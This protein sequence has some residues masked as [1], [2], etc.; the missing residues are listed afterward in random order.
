MKK[1]KFAIVMIICMLGVA[2]VN[3]Q[4]TKSNVAITLER[5]ACF[6]SCPIYTITIL[7]SGEVI[8]NGDRFV[9]VTGE[10]I[11][12]I[13]PETVALMVKA[14]QDAGYF[15]W[16]EAY[17][18]MTVTDMPY[19]TT[20][21]TVDGKTH[22]I[23]RYAGDDSAP[24]ELPFLEQWIDAMTNS[25]L[26][27][28]VKPNV[29]Y[30]SNGGESPVLSIQ[31]D[32]CFGSCPVYNVAIFAD[33]TVVYSG[34]ANV[35]NMGVKTFKV[36]ASSVEGVVQKAKALGYFDWQESYE[37]RVMTDQST[38][39]SSIR[40]EDQSKQIVRYNGDPNAPVG[41]VWIEESIDQL[42]TTV[43]G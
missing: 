40:S 16:K 43:T 6:G 34:I 26:W 25:G 10:Q 13:P 2:S 1:L 11:S 33:G 30:T 37:K 41:L 19:I 36:E 3:A 5:T 22:K 15:D 7:E 4:E 39:T 8:Y 32:A 17:D 14:F 21:V 23:V 18:K 9:D 42:V 24:L 35:T 20:S 38:V 28:G 27:T 12:E 31:H 29:A